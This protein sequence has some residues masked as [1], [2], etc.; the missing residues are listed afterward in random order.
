MGA[1]NRS[2]LQGAVMLPTFTVVSKGAERFFGA[3]RCSFAHLS[4]GRPLPWAHHR[5]QRGFVRWTIA[6]CR[7]LRRPVLVWIDWS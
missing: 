5:S 2:A 4:A 1:C 3:F 6:P 7:V